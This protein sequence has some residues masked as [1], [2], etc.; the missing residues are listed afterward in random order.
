M[1]GHHRNLKTDFRMFGKGNMTG[2]QKCGKLTWKGRN[3][4]FKESVSAP[5]P[6]ALRS[7]RPAH[8]LKIKKT[9]L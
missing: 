6:Q 9:G 3:C 2:A 5:H 4:L 7:Y 1:L 8:G